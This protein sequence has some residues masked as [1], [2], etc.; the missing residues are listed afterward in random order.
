VVPLSLAGPPLRVGA[1]TL[2]PD[3]LLL[4]FS[5]GL[6]ERTGQDQSVGLAELA[7][8]WGRCPRVVGG[9]TAILNRVCGTRSPPGPLEPAVGT[10]GAVEPV[11]R[12]HV[13]VGK[14]E[15]EDLRVLLDALAVCGFRQHDDVAL[16]RPTDQNLGPRAGEPGWPSSPG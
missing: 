9:A 3:E 16:Q 7:D 12:R 13:L 10:A 5:D 11:Q 4:M 15:V 2:A 6:V 8:G 1:P 14:L